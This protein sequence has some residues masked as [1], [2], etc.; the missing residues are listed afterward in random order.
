MIRRAAL[1]TV[2]SV[3]LVT[4]LLVLFEGFAS[5]LR[6]A[7]EIATT[8]PVAERRY[9]T[10]DPDLGWVSVPNTFIPDMYGAGRALRINAQGFRGNEPVTKWVPPG[11]VRVICSGDS[12]TFGYG[13]DNDHG[14]CQQLAA[15]D[16]RMQTVNM[17]QSGYGVD[18]AYLWFKRD[19]AR[20]DHDIHLFAF[21]T[22]DFV[23]M[24]QP[25]FLGYGKPV[26]DVRDGTVIVNNVPVPRSSPFRLWLN[27]LAPT[28]GHLNSVR[29]LQ[30][31]FF[32]RTSAD[33]RSK[34]EVGNWARQL[35]A[36][37]IVD[38]QRLNDARHSA[39]VLVLLP[40]RGDYVGND[41]DFWR[42]FLQ[43]QAAQQGVAFIDMIEALRAVPP[44]QVGQFFIHEGGIDYLAAAGHYTDA[45]N[46]W[47]AA[48][49]YRSLQAL[50]QTAAKLHP[51]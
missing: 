4:V 36:A 25:R 26:L 39:L 28:L 22:T 51:E 17:G 40:T 8:K 30:R 2:F 46:A 13:V 19:G 1:F 14:W 32:P 9:T 42:E 47:V 12:F 21:V 37:V 29:L 3:A 48:T 43:D 16:A 18:Q 5:T 34:E 11:K 15:L 49:L 27:R 35:V 50:P 6:V 7:R 38:L 31:T 20:L 24:L 45:G 44:Q 23:R 10:Y 33:G 41:A